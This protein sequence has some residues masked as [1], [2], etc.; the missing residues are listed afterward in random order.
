M[1]NNEVSGKHNN[2]AN[3]LLFPFP[4]SGHIIPLLDLA[5]HLINH[6]LNITILVTKPFILPLLDPIRAIRSSNSIQTLVL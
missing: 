4:T 2:G 3:V 1:K 5:N 6:N